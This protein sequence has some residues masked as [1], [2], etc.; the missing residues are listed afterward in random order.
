MVKQRT[1]SKKFSLKGKGLHTGRKV[2]ITFHPA[3]ENF[4]YKI[5]RIDLPG[6]PVIKVSVENIHSTDKGVTLSVGEVQVGFVGHGLAALYGCMIDNCL[7]DVNGPEFPLLDGSSI[8]FVYPLSS[9][10]WVNCVY[11]GLFG[12]LLGALFPKNKVN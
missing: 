10:C 1:L 5:R 6:C 11:G 7:I 3:P 4:G 12:G 8:E 9:E 2:R